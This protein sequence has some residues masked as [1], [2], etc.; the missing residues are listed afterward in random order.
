MEELLPLLT[1]A[2]ANVVECIEK[3]I[4]SSFHL[5]KQGQAEGLLLSS[6]GLQHLVGMSRSEPDTTGASVTPETASKVA[7]IETCVKNEI[8]KFGLHPTEPDIEKIIVDCV[9]PHCPGVKSMLT[10]LGCIGSVVEQVMSKNPNAPPQEAVKAVLAHCTT[11]T[12][13]TPV[14]LVPGQNGKPVPLVPDKNGKLVPLVPDHEKSWWQKQP[15]WVRWMIVI[16]GILL[17][18]AIIGGISYNAKKEQIKEK[19]RAVW[20]ARPWQ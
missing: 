3:L 14:P 10:C 19:A 11:C 2:A 17:V 5:G 9:E 6:Q 13:G 1:P 16:G 12:G 4:A 7:N 18:L 20:G 15:A 8:A